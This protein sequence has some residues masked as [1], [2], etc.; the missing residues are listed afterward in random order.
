MTRTLT[1]ILLL[2]AC[3]AQ[4]LP[5]AVKAALDR[6]RSEQA[7][8]DAKLARAQTEAAT[9]NRLI[10]GRLMTILAQERDRAYV[11]KKEAL[12]TELET[13]MASSATTGVP[14]P[15]N[16]YRPSWWTEIRTEEQWAALPGREVAIKAGCRNA[17]VNGGSISVQQQAVIIP[18][19]TDRYSLHDKDPKADYR[20]SLTWTQP[21]PPV[22]TEQVLALLVGNGNS[23]R[24]V[25][26]D[27]VV[28]GPATIL[29]K[30]NCGAYPIDG[31]L[32]IKVVILPKNP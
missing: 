21:P 32:R 17:E 22:E 10:A 11:A 23:W 16:L 8:V 26:S 4:D 30:A 25:A 28:V 12:V 2:A 18:C 20:G 3:A 5:P 27:R 1:L 13:L 15:A 14:V 7:K 6:S 29:L 9:D 24:A 31:Q 19:P